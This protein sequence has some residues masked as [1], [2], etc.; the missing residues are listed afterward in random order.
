[1]D[2]NTL[3]LDARRYRRLQ[4]L[5]CAPGLSENLAK[6]TVL[7]FTNLDEFV[8]TDLKHYPS[9]GEANPVGAVQVEPEYPQLTEEEHERWG[10]D[11]AQRRAEAVQVEP[12]A[13]QGKNCG[14]TVPNL[15]SAECFEEHE[16]TVSKPAG[17]VRCYALDV[18]G[19]GKG[20]TVI[21]PYLQD[22]SDI[23][24]YATPQQAA[25]PEQKGKFVGWVQTD[26][27]SNDLFIVINVKNPNDEKHQPVF[28]A[29]PKAPV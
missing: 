12:V 29:A 27:L 8:D 3:A 24:L 17:Y 2:T 20:Q 10:R 25:A 28:L 22:E 4:I 23:P 7:C 19:N 11:Q 13:C 15:H 16:R 18:L 26:N 6:G 5:G 14:S 21:F 9:R 1:M